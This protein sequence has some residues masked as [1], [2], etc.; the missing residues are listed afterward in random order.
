M[1][2]A[3]ELTLTPTTYSVHAKGKPLFAGGVTTIRLEDEAAGLFLVVRNEHGEFRCDFDEWPLLTKAVDAL[4]FCAESF[5]G[6]P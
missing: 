6:L 2:E 5:D 3:R 4:R 1:S